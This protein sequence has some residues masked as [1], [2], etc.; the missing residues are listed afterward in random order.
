MKEYQVELQVYII[1]EADNAHD[2]EVRAHS[3]VDN[4]PGIIDSDVLEV[5]DIL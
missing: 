1:V 3:W 2:A 4:V 5:M